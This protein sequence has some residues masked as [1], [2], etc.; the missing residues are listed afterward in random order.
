LRRTEPSTLVDLLRERAQEH[1]ERTAYTF[2]LDGEV[3]TSRLT[4]GE[5]DR[6]A[7]AV[8]AL[9]Q[10]RGAAGERAL[11]LFP[12]GLEFVAAFFG[13]LYAGVVA[14][15]AYPPRPGQEQPR[16]RSI[17]ADA[18]PRFALT[19]A[20]L[21]ARL[22]TLGEDDPAFAALGRLTVEPFLDA[23]VAER[24]E[25]WRRPALSGD[26]LAFLQYTSGS[27][28]DPKGVEV[29]HGNLV[30][31]ERLI[32]GTFQQDETA[33]VVGWLPVYHDMGLIGNVLQPLWLGASCVL[34][35]PVAFLRRPRRWL[36]AIA[37]YRGTTSGG[38]NFAY[39][40][41]VDRIGRDE[42]EGL[43][44]SSWRVAF[45]GAEPVRA[46]TLERFA[47]TFGPCGFRREAFQPCYG[48]AEATLLVSGTREG[49]GPRVLRVDAAALEAGRVVDA[50]RPVGP[51][52]RGRD[53]VGSGGIPEGQRVEVVDPVTLKRAAPG[54]VGEIWVAA[55]PG[56]PRG[57]WGRPE[58]TRETFEA[59]LDGEE[60]TFLRTGDLGF[61]RPYQAKGELFITGRIKD[62]IILRGRN[63]YPQDIERTVEASVPGLAP[64]SG[65]AFSIEV[66]GEE[67][68]VV[69]QELQPRLQTDEAGIQEIAAAV[70]RAVSEEH[71]ARVYDVVLLRP[72]EVPK[73]SSG[74]VQRRACRLLYLDGALEVA[75]RSRL[76]AD[77]TTAGERLDREALLALNPAGRQVALETWLRRRAAEVLRV[78]AEELAPDRPLIDLGLDSLAAIE[79]SQAL[80]A[81]LGVPL[82]PAALLEGA[83]ASD[84]AI[85][86]AVALGPSPPGP[87]SRPP[88]PPPRE[89]G[90]GILL[91]ALLALVGCGRGQGGEVFRDAPVILISIDTL[92]SDRLPMYGY[93][94]VETP[95]LDRLRADAV[96]CESA[97]SHYPM[98]LPSHVSILSGQL[99]PVHGVRDNTGYAFEAAGHPYLPRLFKEAGYDTGAAVSSYVLRGSTGLS[100]GFDFYE[101]SLKAEQD[102]TMDAVQRA[103]GETARLAL[104]WVRGRGERPFFLFF[105]IY[106]P[107]FPYTPPPP[108]AER[109]SDRYDGEVAAS[110]KIVGDFLEELRRLGIYDKAVIVLLSDHGEGLGDHGEYQHS[111]FLYR[112][113]V[114]VPLLVKLPGARHAGETVRGLTQLADVFPTLAALAGLPA[115]EGLPGTSILSLLGAETPPDREVYAETWYPRLHFGWSELT[116]LVRGPHQYIEAPQPE[117]YDLEADPRQTRNILARNRRLYADLRRR[118]AAYHKPLAPPGQVDQETSEKLASLGYL[119]GG[120]LAEG[121]LPDPK[122]KRPLM[123]KLE[124]AAALTH[125]GDDEGA[126]RLLRAALDEDPRMVDVWG[127]LAASLRRLGRRE[128]AVEAFQKALELS[129]GSPQLALVT[130]MTLFESNRL[131]EAEKHAELAVAADPKRA[132]ELLIRIAL[133]RPDLRRAHDLF[134]RSA[135]AGAASDEM[136]RQIALLL[137]REGRA[138]EAIALLEPA[139]A[140]GDPQTLTALGLAYVEAGRRPEAMAAFQRAIDRAPADPATARAH[141][142]L[143][144]LFLGMDRPGEARA[145]LRRALELNDQL[146]GSWNTLGVALYRL[147]GPAAALEAWQRAVALDGKQY[148]A[149][150]NIGLVAASTGRPQEARQALRQFVATAPPQRFAADLQKARSILRELGG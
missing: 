111:I 76:A 96:L 126:A 84:L 134:Q 33:V 21:S 31:M 133:A 102:Q 80:E 32:A 72:G 38:P 55:G 113:V 50:A 63:L 18:R 49:T 64:G 101:D 78:P 83:S 28:A 1:P 12:P 75:G 82:S 112:E 43:D 88:S 125:S 145:H 141:Q 137:A 86:A 89:R 106:E 47:R 91:L 52:P 9:L 8:A 73:T 132:Y 79:L 130:A 120:V 138:G 56:I 16:L 19:T 110:D 143:G 105:H 104:D 148:D 94:K 93:E 59:R 103:G 45:N 128:E 97:F 116:S 7:R 123:R 4:Y 144:G 25:D 27:T 70:R 150:F 39:D 119:G 46:A 85:S 42:C 23:G 66:D 53:L 6:Q 48:L 34:M 61:V 114:Q 30:F 17:L 117:L 35:S 2:L 29:R 71:E 22:K 14:V 121:P 57:Y 51:E 135:A 124:D 77:G 142:E 37:R 20:A 41:C 146:A 60:G 81:E 118:T 131:G 54:E 67:R 100:Q 99:P 3:E 69:A 107:H 115:P 15:P 5:L 149:L 129:N 44:L 11:L 13:C 90:R 147:E 26:S 68:L 58:V 136:R 62:L 10:E 65:A 95:A 108:F 40:L 127:Q 139:A 92:R 36:E 87:L 98:T 140:G 24:A 122:G 109:Y 74:K